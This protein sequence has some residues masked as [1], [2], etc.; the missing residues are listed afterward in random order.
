MP[1][2]RR[3]TTEANLRLVQITAGEFS[4]VRG[5][6]YRFC[7]GSAVAYSESGGGGWR[8]F[9]PGQEVPEPAQA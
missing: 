2:L 9:L 3:P 4:P 5:E 7:D 1:R 8:V 6:V